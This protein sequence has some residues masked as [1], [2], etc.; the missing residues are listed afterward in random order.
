MYVCMYVRAYLAQSIRLCPRVC[1]HVCMYVC[2][3][4][5]MYVRSMCVCMYVCV[6]VCMYVRVYAY[7]RRLSHR[8]PLP[9]MAS[10]SLAG[11]LPHVSVY[12]PADPRTENLCPD[13]FEHSRSCCC[14]MNLVLQNGYSKSTYV[15]I[16]VCVCVCIPANPRI[17]NLCPD[18]LVHSC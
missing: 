11:Y 13:C 17:E 15:C 2:V 10:C 8:E 1:M 9:Q 5:C 12:M 7:T 4:V 6:Y 14:A 18:G 3:C 16:Y